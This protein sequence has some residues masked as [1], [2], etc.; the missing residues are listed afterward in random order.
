M[1]LDAKLLPLPAARIKEQFIKDL[2]ADK[3]VVT[4]DESFKEEA[5]KYHLIV[6]T[7]PSPDLVP[8]L[9]GLARPF[10]VLCQL[11]APPRGKLCSFSAGSIISGQI[12]IVGSAIGSRKEIREML[13]FSSKHNIVPLCE[14][15]DFE[16]F[17]K[18]YDRLVNGKPI[19]RC[20]V[21]CTK[22]G[23]KH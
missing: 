6:N 7:L 18:A 19:F 22:A 1:R 9:V 21:D 8:S 5:G 17:P 15:F 3:V 10:G 13:E 11:G 4:N 16:D 12:S 2:G 23:P 20:V 14:E